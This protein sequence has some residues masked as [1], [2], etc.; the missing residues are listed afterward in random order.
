LLSTSEETERVVVKLGDFGLST[1]VND[2][3]APSTY[4]GTKQYLAPV[5]LQNLVSLYMTNFSVAG[6][7]SFK[8]R[9]HSLD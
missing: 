7:H 3:K 2:E 5:N 4:A 9:S 6:N 1:F 8:A